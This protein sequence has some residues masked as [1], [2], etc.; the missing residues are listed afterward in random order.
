M[1]SLAVGIVLGAF[2]VAIVQDSDAVVKFLEK[3]TK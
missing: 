1:L 3:A 2:L